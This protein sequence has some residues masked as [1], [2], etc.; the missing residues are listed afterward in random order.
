MAKHKRTLA[1]FLKITHALKLQ[2][3][4]TNNKRGALL[5][6]MKII[7]YCVHFNEQAIIHFQLKAL[8]QA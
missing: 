5:I 1:Q 2:R 8:L 4:I 6:Q 3:K 7:R